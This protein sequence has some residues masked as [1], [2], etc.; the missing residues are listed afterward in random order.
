MPIFMTI[1]Q[2][3]NKNKKFMAIFSKDIKG[4]RQVIK[5]T[6]FG[7]KGAED[8]TIHGDKNR[9]KNYRARHKSDLEKGNYMSAGYLSYYLLWGEATSLQSNI[10]TYKKR[11]KLK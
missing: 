7:Q 9:R 10:N 4:K 11:F 3:T 8:Y 6:H 2:S 1:K 5:I